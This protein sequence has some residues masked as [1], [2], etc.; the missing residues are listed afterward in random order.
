MVSRNFII[1]N[2]TG[3][4]MRPA[5][6]F[7]QAMTKYTGDV[8]ILFNGKR[9]NG[10][11]MIGIMTSCIKYGSDVTVECNGENENAMLEE[12]AEMIENGF[13]EG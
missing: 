9:V 7:T 13:G 1:K 11:S 4:H 10:K 5:Q 6:A 8:S 12:A 3:L 2:K